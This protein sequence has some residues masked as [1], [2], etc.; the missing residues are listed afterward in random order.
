MSCWPPPT[1]K[2]LTWKG[3]ADF[4]NNP[5]K[6]QRAG[7]LR[8]NARIIAGSGLDKKTLSEAD[9]CEKLITPA[10][11]QAGWNTVEQIYREYTLRP[12]R[13]VVR[14][15]H[16]ARDRKSVLRADYVLFYKANI[17]LVVVEAK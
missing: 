1:G 8:A 10:I 2:R 17:P 16:A 5:I 4:V 14:G 6:Q 15:N 12:G 9:I 3:S 11:Q 13:V 7:K